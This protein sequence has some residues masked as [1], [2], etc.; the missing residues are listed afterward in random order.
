MRLRG[1]LHWSLPP[2]MIPIFWRAFVLR[3]LDSLQISAPCFRWGEFPRAHIVNARID[4]LFERLGSFVDIDE[5]ARKLNSRLVE[6]ELLQEVSGNVAAK[7]AQGE[8]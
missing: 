7:E 5:A 6:L 3:K 4:C 8:R 2:K 1:T